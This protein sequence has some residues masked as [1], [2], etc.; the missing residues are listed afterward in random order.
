MENDRLSILRDLRAVPLVIALAGAC[1]FS[2][3]LQSQQA[4][5]KLPQFETVSIKPTDPDRVGNSGITPDGYR[6]EN[7]TLGP[8]ILEAYGL[9]Q[10]YQIVGLPKW[11][12]SAHYEILAKVGD[13][14]VPALKPLGYSQMYRMLRPVLEDR[15]SLR[16]HMEKRMLPAFR[17]EVS[18]KN[19]LLMKG[20]DSSKPMKVGAATVGP[21]TMVTT[22]NGRVVAMAVPVEM[23]VSLLARELHVYVVDGTGL[24]DK[25]DFEMQLPTMRSS[26]PGYDDSGL[27]RP[28]DL[29]E[30]GDLVQDGLSQIGLKLVPLKTELPVLV[31][32]ELKPPSSN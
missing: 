14:D 2:V 13:A 8:L 1:L 32:D 23:L 9:K 27:P 4:P 21:G 26:S 3:G 17:L 20:S 22:A 11:A 25:Y 18:G 30:A 6:G 19:P 5:A 15:F 12:E 28:P 29:S 16:Y 24:K 7:V 31:I 10:P